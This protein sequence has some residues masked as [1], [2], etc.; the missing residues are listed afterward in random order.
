MR[1]TPDRYRSVATFPVPSIRFLDR[2]RVD[3]RTG[4]GRNRRDA[5]TYVTCPDHFRDCLNNYV[6]HGRIKASGEKREREREMNKEDEKS[7]N[8]EIS[9]VRTVLFE[10]TRGSVAV[11]LAR[12]VCYG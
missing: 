11:Y 12:Y 10:L 1:T 9:R 2:C 7:E 6:K 4:L 8:N 3:R 5:V